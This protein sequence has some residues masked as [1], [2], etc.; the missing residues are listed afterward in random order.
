MRTA[1]KRKKD[2]RQRASRTHGWGGKK[3]HRGSGHR[4]GFGNAGTGKRGDAKKPSIWKDSKYFGKFG[5]KK[6]NIPVKINAISIKAL[7]SEMKHLLAIKAAEEKS[8]I[9]EIDIEKAGYNKLL[10]NG[11]ATLKMKIKAPYASAKAVEKIKSA[12]G[13]VA[14]LRAKPEEKA[15]E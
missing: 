13:E 15:S 6:K 3:K 5:F 2:T 1:N 7:I 11:K 14:G 12:G 9:Y 10:S 8:G 4:G